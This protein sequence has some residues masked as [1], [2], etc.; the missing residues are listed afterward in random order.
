MGIVVRLL[1]Y[2][3]WAASASAPVWIF[4]TR[5]LGPVFSGLFIGAAVGVCLSQYI[6]EE[7]WLD[8]EWMG[9]PGPRKY[10]AD[11]RYA[12]PIAVRDGKYIVPMFAG[13]GVVVGLLVR[14]IGKVAGYD[15]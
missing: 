1:V 7:W 3:L 11:L 14:A 13:F 4:G 8:Y 6:A 10:L 2:A 9:A 12:I 5:E 15:I